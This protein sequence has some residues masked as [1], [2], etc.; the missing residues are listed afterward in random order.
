M[1]IIRV[2]KYD[3]PP[4][5]LVWKYPSQELGTWTQL[6]V[7]ESQEAMLFLEGQA[8][9]LYTA[10]RHTLSTRNVPLFISL[11]KLPFGGKSP[12]TAEVWYVNKLRTLTVKWG[13]PAPI[14]L[15]D[16][17]YGLPISLRAFGQF[18][19]QIEDTR[20]FLTQVVGTLGRYD[21]EEI[22]KHFRAIITMNIN[23]YL[24]AYLIH[25]KINILEI[26]AYIGEVSR[27]IEKKIAPLF[28]T[29][30]VRLLNFNTDSINIPE[31]DAMTSRLKEA[32]ATKAERDILGSTVSQELSFLKP[33]VTP[34]MKKPALRLDDIGDEL[35]IEFSLT[36]SDDAADVDE[37]EFDMEDPG[38]SKCGHP[39]VYGSKFCTNC[40]D[41]YNPCP[42]CLTDN[43]T[44]AV[45]CK[46]CGS[47][48]GAACH[49]CGATI[50][51]G[52]KFCPECGKRVT[53][54][55]SR[56]RYELEPGQK[57]CPECGNQAG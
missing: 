38:C 9:E 29:F 48:M 2:V 15:K 51:K 37:G 4:D 41:P 44:D 25:K 17:V 52:S 42:V 28:Q 7:N 24:S 56:C 31:D 34:P 11:V 3:G 10:G 35:K 47:E 55:C 39:L 12:F 33:A 27:H 57:F 16:P 26:N 30:G 1:A 43:E 19:I 49:H 45:H 18:G 32:L 50:P 22:G 5:E 8:T 14:Q 21:Q 6:I 20:M 40:G 23:E 46:S 13:T 36:A 53:V 54:T